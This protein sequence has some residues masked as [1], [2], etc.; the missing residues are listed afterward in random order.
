MSNRGWTRWLVALLSGGVLLAGCGGGSDFKNEPRPPTPIQLTG[1][2]KDNAVTVS[3]NKVGAGPIVLLIA[4]ESAN[5]HT[6]TLTGANLDAQVGPVNPQ[7]TAKLQQTLKP[8][9]YTVKA[10]SSSAV[11]RQPK[12]AKLTIGPERQSSSDQVNLP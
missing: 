5:A 7:D 6:V 8:G 3:P 10:G 12:P 11:N 2:I 4:N 1:V 9:T